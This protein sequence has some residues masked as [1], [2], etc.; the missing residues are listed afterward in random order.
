MA[1][2]G[3]I[4]QLGYQVLHTG[5]VGSYGMGFVVSPSPP[6]PENPCYGVVMLVIDQ[7][8][9]PYRFVGAHK[10]VWRDGVVVFPPY[11]DIPYDVVFVAKSTALGKGFY[12]QL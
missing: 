10:S 11:P 12:I 1:V 3:V 6:L 8:Q 9:P 7:V 2:T 5:S 4:N